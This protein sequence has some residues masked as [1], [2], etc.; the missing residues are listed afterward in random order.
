MNA[1]REPLENN[2]KRLKSPTRECRE[3]A[4]WPGLERPRETSAIDI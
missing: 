1:H 3:T 4:G 2:K